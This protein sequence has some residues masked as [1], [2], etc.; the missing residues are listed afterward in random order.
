MHKLKQ[1]LV[2]KSIDWVNQN[3]IQELEPLVR[4]N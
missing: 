4:P 2:K 3:K 1:N